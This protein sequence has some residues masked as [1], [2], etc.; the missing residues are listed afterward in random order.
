MEKGGHVRNVVIRT[1]PV[2]WD[3]GGL[4]NGT[5]SAVGRWTARPL[6]RLARGNV[7]PR[8]WIWL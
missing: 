1:D 3:A 2:L 5:G 4:P 8:P 7:V 6:P